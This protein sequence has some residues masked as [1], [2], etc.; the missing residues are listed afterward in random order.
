MVSYYE[1]MISLALRS[2]QYNEAIT[3]INDAYSVLDRVG[4]SEQYIKYMLTVILIYL[5]RDDWVSAK[6]YLDNMQ[7]KCID[8]QWVMPLLFKCLN[9]LF[10]F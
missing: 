6:A 9:M 4:S 2:N 1:N 3:I 7:Q 10:Y 5:S 8:F